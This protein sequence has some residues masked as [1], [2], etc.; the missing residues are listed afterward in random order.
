VSCLRRERGQ[1]TI[2]WVSLVL[3]ASLALGA[4]ATAVPLV[5]GRSFGGFLSHHLTCVI[6]GTDRCDEGDAAL[7]RAHGADDAALLRR[8][9]PG[10]VYEPGER[11]LPVDY[12]DCRRPAC[13]RAP[14][15]PDLDAHRTDAGH[16]ATSFTHVV[17]RGGRVY[18][19]YCTLR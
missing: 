15:D 2:E 9:A 6:A 5:D 11:Q 10:L 3:L 14:D 17:R 19:Q 1:A 4:L 12:R 7:A 18:L 16:P 8:F 13:A